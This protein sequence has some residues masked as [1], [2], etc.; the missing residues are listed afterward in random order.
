[1]SS[2]NPVFI[3]SPTK[4]LACRYGTF[5]H[6]WIDMCKHQELDVQQ[7]NAPWGAGM[8]SGIGSAL[9]EVA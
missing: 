8:R 2:H 7:L 3:P 1:M 6:R 9:S 4:I 5:S